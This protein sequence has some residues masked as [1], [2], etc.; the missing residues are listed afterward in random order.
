MSALEFLCLTLA[1][2][3]GVAGLALIGRKGSWV[4]VAASLVLTVL[5]L[6]MLALRL[7]Q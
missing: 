2:A 4:C 1:M 6:V 5:A 3:S 7:T